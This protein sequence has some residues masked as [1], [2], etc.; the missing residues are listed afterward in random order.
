MLYPPYSLGLAR[1]DYHLFQG[2]QNNLHGLL[3]EEVLTLLISLKMKYLFGTLYVRA[4]HN[5]EDIGDV[6]YHCLYILLS[7][8]FWYVNVYNFVPNIT[9]T[10]VRNI[11]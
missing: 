8:D 6:T 11:K 1:S 7:N 4:L 9:F 10:V 3:I 5:I 2:L